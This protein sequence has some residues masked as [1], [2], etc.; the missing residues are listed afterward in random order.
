MTISFHHHFREGDLVVNL[1]IEALAR[2][3][4]R[5]LVLAPSS[6][7]Y[8]HERLI[9]RVKDGTIRRIRTSGLRG[10]AGRRHQRRTDGRTCPDPL[11]RRTG[12]GD[13]RRRTGRRRGLHRSTGLRRDGQRHG[14]RRRVR[15]R[16][17]WLR[18]GR[19]P[20]RLEGRDADRGDRPLPADAGVDTAGLRRSSSSRSTR[21]A[22]RP[23]SARAP[24][25]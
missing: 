15:L 23:A 20:R 10:K 21:S 16:I 5:D 18:D 19:R 12:P 22:T 6:L 24:P 3:G 8:V 2:R 1:V 13:G 25:A 9:D 14:I 4:V 17:A 11:A 7:T